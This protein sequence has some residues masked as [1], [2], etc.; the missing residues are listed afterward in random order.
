MTLELGG[1]TPV[2]ILPDADLAAAIPSA[3]NAIFFN[4]GQVSIAGS[5]LY[6][7]RSVDD[8]VAEAARGIALGFGL[9]PATQM[10]H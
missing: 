6:A 2:I 5:R 4:G 1:E 10:G 8:R 9:N 7:H 3:A